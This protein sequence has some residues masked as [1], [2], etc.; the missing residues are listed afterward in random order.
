MASRGDY[1]TILVQQH[2]SGVAEAVVAETTSVSVDFSAEALETTSQTSGLNA[3]FIAGKVS[4]T[5]SGDFLIASDAANLSLLFAKMNAGVTVGVEVEIAGS[6]L[7]A[8]DGVITGLTM[9]GGNSDTLA[10]GSYTIQCSG[11]MAV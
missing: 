6:A 1:L 9:G 3:S 7:F 2:S 4:C 10:T 5:C 11:D 8:G